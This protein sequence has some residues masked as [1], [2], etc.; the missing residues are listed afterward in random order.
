MAHSNRYVLYDQMPVS[1]L[2]MFLY[3]YILHKEINDTYIISKHGSLQVC[4]VNLSNAL[5]A[6]K[7]YR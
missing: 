7:Y 2:C 4:S 1:A 3:V 6:N 5:M